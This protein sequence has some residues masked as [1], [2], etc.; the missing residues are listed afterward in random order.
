ME[1]GRQ[2]GVSL[3]LDKGAKGNRPGITWSHMNYT[4]P[5]FFSRFNHISIEPNNDTT[6]TRMYLL[7]V[8]VLL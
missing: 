7:S 3:G 4:I 1:N 8:I 2:G 6:K 5:F